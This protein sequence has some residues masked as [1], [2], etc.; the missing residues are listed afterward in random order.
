MYMYDEASDMIGVKAVC[1]GDRGIQYI[2]KSILSKLIGHQNI[3]HALMFVV[4]KTPK[5]REP[6]GI[7]STIHSQIFVS[8]YRDPIALIGSN[9]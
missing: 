2:C 8:I 5:Q 7:D 3:T 1:M 9:G 6:F 4:N